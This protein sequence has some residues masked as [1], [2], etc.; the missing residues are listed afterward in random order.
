MN[1]HMKQLTQHYMLVKNIV[2]VI[3]H[4]GENL[5]LAAEEFEAADQEISKLMTSSQYI[6][7]GREQLMEQKKGLALQKIT[8]QMTQ[9]QQTYDNY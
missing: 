6:M 8:Q 9:V 1:R 3:R 4:S 2:E 7:V 5:Q